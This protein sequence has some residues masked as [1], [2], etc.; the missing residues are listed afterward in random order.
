MKIHLETAREHGQI[1]QFIVQDN[2][3]GGGLITISIPSENCAIE[4]GAEEL[5]RAIIAVQPIRYMLADLLDEFG[6]LH[7]QT[8]NRR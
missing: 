2:P 8:I 4:V 5:L 1:R 3:G 6:K 7:R